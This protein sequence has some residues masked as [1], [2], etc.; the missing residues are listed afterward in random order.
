[1]HLPE[2]KMSSMHT[3]DI[4]RTQCSRLQKLQISRSSN[5]SFAKVC[6]SC[7][8]LKCWKMSS[9]FQKSVSIQLLAR[10]GSIEDVL[11]RAVAMRHGCRPSRDSSTTRRLSRAGPFRSVAWRALLFFY[12]RPRV[13][14]EPTNARTPDLPSILRIS[15]FFI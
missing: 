11:P 3:A 12:K 8:S 10:T 9:W 14:S 1:M 2:V 7:R 5:F 4:R 15:R 6:R 13:V